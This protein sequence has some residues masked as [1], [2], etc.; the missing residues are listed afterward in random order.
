MKRVGQRTHVFLGHHDAGVAHDLGDRPR[1][2]AHHGDP[3][4]HG[5]ERRARENLDPPR[6]GAR[7]GHQHVEL[8]PDLFH[9]AARQRAQPG[10]PPGDLAGAGQ[11]FELLLGGTGPHH[12]DRPAAHQL[13]RRAEEQVEALFR[14][15]PAHESE[16]ETGVRRAHDGRRERHA[17]LRDGAVRQRVVSP[18]REP[19]C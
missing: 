15:E 5:L 11:P 3:V 19:A 8:R 13:H 4:G 1:G 10:H 9:A 6:G 18:K 12:R 7:G 2:A 14:N 16:R 17:E